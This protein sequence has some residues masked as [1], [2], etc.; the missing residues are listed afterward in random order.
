MSLTQTAV[1]RIFDKWALGIHHSPTG[2][3]LV[4]G[5]NGEIVELDQSLNEL[6]RW[7]AHEGSVGSLR[8]IDGKVW[9]GGGDALIKVWEWPSLDVAQV[10]EGPK[11][12][13]TKFFTDGGQLIALSYDRAAFVWSLADTSQPRGD[14]GSVCA[15][16]QALIRA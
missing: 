6:R 9:T 5:M 1:V 16:S 10:F 3:V 12:P 2:T 4:T 11:K 15:S 13:I 7:Q 14:F 8:V